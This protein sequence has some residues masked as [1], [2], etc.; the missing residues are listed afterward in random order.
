MDVALELPADSRSDEITLQILLCR[1]CAFEG[2]A[3]YEE[4]RRGALGKELFEHIGYRVNEAQLASLREAID[5]C[6]EPRNSDCACSTHAA[7]AETNDWG[8][9]VGLNRVELITAFPI[10]R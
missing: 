4:S 6:P 3:V 1:K 10:E 5:Q 9:W 7:L 2:L 8:R